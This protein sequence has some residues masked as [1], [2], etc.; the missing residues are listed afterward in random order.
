MSTMRAARYHGQR[1]IRVEEIPI[2]QPGPG[3]CLVE[4]EWC[5]ICGS[6]LHEYTAGPTA[7]PT[8]ERPNPLTGGTLPVTLGHEFCGRIK[9]VGE[10]AKFQ[11]GQPVMVDP[12]VGCRSCPSCTSGMDHVCHMLSFMG[13]SGGKLG[14]GLS[15]YVAV[16]ES[17]LYPL[18]ENVSM[19]FAA[20]IE[21][22]VVGQHAAKAA[23][24]KLEGQDILIVG[25]GPI[26]VAMISVLRAHRVGKIF[27][28]EPTAKRWQHAKD[29]VERVIDPKNE[30]VGDICRE[31]TGGKG[32]D[33]V[34]DCAGVQPGLESGM[35]A[36]KHGGTLVNVAV[37]EKPL[38]IQFWP[39]FLKEI[40]IMSSCCYNKQDFAEVMELMSKNEFKGYEQMVTSRIPLE[41]VVSKG[42]EELVNNR[43]DHI[44]ILISPKIK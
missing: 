16:E 14:G 30:S 38:Q 3:E 35:D 18:P 22:L 26:G 1:D 44:K 33:V 19:D 9:A 11:I 24:T 39:F 29:V 42:F 28:S 27:L 5:G 43:D 15:E 25:G 13:Y 4:I 31:L 34:F 17:H 6:D 8:A 21:P 40:K 32:A 12:H 7:I 2:P 37:W 23:G 20:V 10:G 36:I 41:E